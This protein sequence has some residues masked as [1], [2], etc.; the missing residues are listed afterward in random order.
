MGTEDSPE[1]EQKNSA[2][3]AFQIKYFGA[4]A[5]VFSFV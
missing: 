2:P 5:R 4:G 3:S 1:P